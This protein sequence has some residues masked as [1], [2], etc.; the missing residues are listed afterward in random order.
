[1]FDDCN[2]F[3]KWNM[4][5]AAGQTVPDLPLHTTCA[6]KPFPRLARDERSRQLS[7]ST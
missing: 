5:P 1:M 2:G 6:E 4:V 3:I 7:S